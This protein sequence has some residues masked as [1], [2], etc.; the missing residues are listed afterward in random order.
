MLFSIIRAI[1]LEKTA[2][3]NSGGGTA[4]VLPTPKTSELVPN[5][6]SQSPCMTSSV[7]TA[8]LSVMARPTMPA[9]STDVNRQGGDMLSREDA[10]RGRDIY[11]RFKGQV[12]KNPK[13]RTEDKKARDRDCSNVSKWK[14]V[15]VEHIL[16]IQSIR[17]DRV[18]SQIFCELF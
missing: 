9:S 1:D 14:G 12:E 17:L 10:N 18:F 4:S 8:G 6:A 13:V 5:I 11:G 7:P 2:S 16:K 15:I 3:E